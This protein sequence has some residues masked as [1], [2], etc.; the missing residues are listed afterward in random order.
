[1]EEQS[2]R[3]SRPASA[4]AGVVAAGGAV[5][6]MGWTRSAYEVRTLQE[7]IM[8]WAL[9]FVPT[10]LFEQG[11]QRFGTSAKVIAVQVAMVIIALVLAA[12][13]YAAV[14]RG[15]RVVLATSVL[16]WL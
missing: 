11:L 7:R 15:A 6:L 1:M 14:R 9:L 3:P 5:G 4:A 13:G 12:V 10:D 8:E 2:T 16:L